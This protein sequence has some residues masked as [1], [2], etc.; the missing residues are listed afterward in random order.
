MTR[1]Y[2]PKIVP[3]K[4]GEGPG[5]DSECNGRVIL[6]GTEVY[7]P[8]PRSGR[9]VTAWTRLPGK[10]P[11]VRRSS[12]LAGRSGTGRPVE[13]LEALCRFCVSDAPIRLDPVYRRRGEIARYCKREARTEGE[14]FGPSCGG[15]RV[16]SVHDVLG[17]NVEYIGHRRW[18]GRRGRTRAVCVPDCGPEDL[19]L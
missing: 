13:G 9:W 16:S 14:T 19:T 7:R 15:R 3:V 11:C 12:D 18:V 17:P 10:E 4:D 8:G 2:V 5:G 1:V 6:E